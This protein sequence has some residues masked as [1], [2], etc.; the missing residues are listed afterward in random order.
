VCVLSGCLSVSVITPES[1]HEIF[2]WEVKR[3]TKFE[4]RAGDLEYLMFYCFVEW[5]PLANDNERIDE[6]DN[7]YIAL[8]GW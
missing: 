3:E 8:R 2:R 4:N 1:Y 7:C 5:R 6:Y